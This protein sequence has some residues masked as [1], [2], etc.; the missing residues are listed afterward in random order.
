M[1]NTEDEDVAIS[2]EDIVSMIIKRQRLWVDASVVIANMLPDVWDA[3]EGYLAETQNLTNLLLTDMKYEPTSEIL[4][5]SVFEQGTTVIYNVPIPLG[6]AVNPGL[7]SEYLVAYLQKLPNL[8]NDGKVPE[9]QEDK[10]KNQL[11]YTLQ[12]HPGMFMDV[13]RLTELEIQSAQGT[14]IRYSV[15]EKLQ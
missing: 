2:K 12:Q 14:F 4:T 13:D 3:I 6:L 10:I 15:A 8:V 1:D 7:D 9:T 11:N 5:Y